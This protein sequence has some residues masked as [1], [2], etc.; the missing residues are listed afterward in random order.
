M[1]KKFTKTSC[2]ELQKIITFP[3]K[4]ILKSQLNII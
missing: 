3:F 4:E 2:K 1:S